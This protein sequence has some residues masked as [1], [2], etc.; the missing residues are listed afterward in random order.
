[1]RGWNLNRSS[2]RLGWTRV[3]RVNLKERNPPGKGGKILF[4][5]FSSSSTHSI[6]LLP[7]DQPFQPSNIRGKRWNGSPP[8]S[9][10]V[11][12]RSYSLTR[13]NSQYKGWKTEA[14]ARKTTT[15]TLLGRVGKASKY[16]KKRQD[17][18]MIA[19]M[20]KY[21][22]HAYIN[23]RVGA[24]G[25]SG[26]LHEGRVLDWREAEYVKKK[27]KRSNEEVPTILFHQQMANRD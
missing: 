23:A 20:Y 21:S 4:S 16:R 5:S 25:L 3:E 2:S 22:L 18:R 27:K 12:F 7:I 1:M 10:P 19:S 8:L 24:Q 9:S 6:S 14:I 13:T 26:F 15:E 17:G 11:H